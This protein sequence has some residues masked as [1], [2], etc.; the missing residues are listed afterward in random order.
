MNYFITYIYWRGLKMSDV[1][2]RIFGLSEQ[3]LNQFTDVIKKEINEKP[4]STENPFKADTI[5]QKYIKIVHGWN[6]DNYVWHISPSHERR[7][8]KYSDGRILY[9]IGYV[10]NEVMPKSQIFDVY[11]PDPDWKLKEI[12]YKGVDM[13]LNW[14]VTEND[15]NKLNIRLLEVLS[16]LV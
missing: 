15:I 12:T 11:P 13:K 4:L 8:W 14:S 6:G 9:A 7:P 2:A 5:I 10:F 1:L 16:A 3:E